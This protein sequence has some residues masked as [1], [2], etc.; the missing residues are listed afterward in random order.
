[1]AGKKETTTITTEQARKL[2]L[3]KQHLVGEPPKGSFRERATSL[4]RDIAYVQ[5]DP[6]TILAPSHMISLWSRIGNFDWKELDNLMWETKNAFLYWAP[7][8]FLVLT[9]DYPIFHS[10]ME[11]YPDS[12]GSAWRNHI[13]PARKFLDSHKELQ[14]KVFRRLES[15]PLDSGNLNEM[16]KRKKSGDGWSSGNEVTRMLSQLHMLGKVMVSGHSGNQNLWSLTGQ[17]LPA[18]AEIK[19]LPVG[20]LEQNTTTRSFKALGAASDFDVNRYFVRGRYRILDQVLGNME[21]EGLIERIMIEGQKGRRNYFIRPED[22]NAI[23]SMDSFDWEGN[24]RLI[25][26]FDNIINNR[27]RAERLFNFSYSLEQFLP[28]EKRKYGTYV[29][30]VLWKDQLVARIDAKLEKEERVLNIISAHAE[31]G[32]EKEFEIP[33]RLSGLLHEFAPFIGA[34]SI[35]AGKNMPEGWQSRISR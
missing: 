7:I 29:L 28:K 23:E 4:I 21:Y 18:W 9:E 20:D 33:D 17:F 10:L 16:G 35:A 6:V 30:P 32:F 27:E 12:L 5:W 13:E 11:E 34:E 2:F 1:M 25:A 19:H 8:A 15:G 26:P 3:V 22:L 24:I 14:E 31:S